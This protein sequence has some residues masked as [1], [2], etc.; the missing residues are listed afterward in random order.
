MIGLEDIAGIKSAE[1]GRAVALA[2][3]NLLNGVRAGALCIDCMKDIMDD[4]ECDD[5]ADYAVEEDDN[6]E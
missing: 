3:Y 5:E 2:I 1:E 6:D 4:C